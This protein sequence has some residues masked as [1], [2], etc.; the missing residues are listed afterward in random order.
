MVKKTEDEEFITE[1]ECEQFRQAVKN[2]VPLVKKTYKFF[3]KVNKENKQNLPTIADKKSNKSSS[4][5]AKTQN[6]WVRLKRTSPTLQKPTRFTQKPSIKNFGY[7][8]Q[9]KD[10]KSQEQVVFF[11]PGLPYREQVKLKRGHCKIG[12]RIDLHQLNVDQALHYCEE[13]IDECQLKNIRYALII[14]GKAE[15]APLPILKNA[16]NRWLRNQPAIL[17]FH[18]AKPEQ[19]GTGALYIVIRSK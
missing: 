13:F 6:K 14:H 5:T 11:R 2:V 9:S 15:H 7:D 12:A 3:S 19:G 1:E 17:A 8:F 10:V 4:S 18:S 16:L